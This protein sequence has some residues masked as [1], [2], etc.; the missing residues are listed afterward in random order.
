MAI[1]KN[2]KILM[3]VDKM[4]LGM[5]TL[6]RDEELSLVSARLLLTKLALSIFKRDNPPPVTYDVLP[7]AEELEGV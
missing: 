2:Q 7:P 3:R 4:L 1:N 6:T 5:E